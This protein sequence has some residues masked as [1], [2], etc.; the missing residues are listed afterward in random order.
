MRGEGRPGKPAGAQATCGTLTSWRS[1]VVV[2]RIDQLGARARA[3]WQ[4]SS[5]RP[6]S[7]ARNLSRETRYQVPSSARTQ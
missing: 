7:A 3:Y 5:G 4:S 2:E 6:T 1:T